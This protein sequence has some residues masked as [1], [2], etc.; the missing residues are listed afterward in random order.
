MAQI[1]RLVIAGTNS[2]VGKTSITLA[3]TAA[4]RAKGLDVQTFKVGPDYLDPSYLKLVS[5]R[6]CYNLDGWMTGREYVEDLFTSGSEDADIVLIEGV[7][8]L[9]DGSD[10]ANNEGSTAEIANWL[11]A[12]VILVT[13]VRGMARSLAALVKGFVE[14]GPEIKIAGVIANNC[15]SQ[16]HAEWLSTALREAGLPG[17]VGSL[18]RGVFPELPHRHLG[19]ITADERVLT[20]EMIAGFGE[21]IGK[22]CDLDNLMR[23]AETA[24]PATSKRAP[25]PVAYTEIRIGIALDAAFHFYY[26]DN[27]EALEAAGCELVFF[28]P[29]NDSALP[30]DLDGLYIG[31]GYPEEHAL[32]L[33]DNSSMLE[34]VRAFVKSGKPVYAEC[35]GLMY[36]SEGIELKDGRFHELVSI[37]PARTKMLPGRKRLG[38]VEVSLLQDSLLGTSGDIL[39]GHE[40]HYSELMSLPDQS[41]WKPVY[42]LTYRRSDKPVSEGYQ[43]GNVL[44][45]YAHTHFASRP[46]AVQNFKT[47]CLKHRE[48]NT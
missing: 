42:S 6:Q 12:P 45:T 43:K 29:L 46:K 21:S 11:N 33:A 44:A 16:R 37:L 32:N 34:S 5:G 18:P 7:M 30:D 1:P 3:L 23:L 17:L 14:F 10:P 26:E 38:Y 15:G 13:N 39:R 25:W 22:C 20:A 9:Y 24:P 36:L 41:E 19:L 31:G 4:L 2:G 8:G 47:L 28:S 40:F 35:G 48:E 27:L